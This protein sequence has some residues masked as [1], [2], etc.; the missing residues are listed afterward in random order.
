M[1]NQGVLPPFVKEDVFEPPCLRRG[2][3]QKN[4]LG[5]D[6]NL[7]DPKMEMGKINYCGNKKIKTNIMLIKSLRALRF[8]IRFV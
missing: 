3:N 6:Q 8:C 4:F 2:E 5:R 7:C 1:G